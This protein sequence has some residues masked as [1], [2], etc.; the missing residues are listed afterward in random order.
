MVSGGVSRVPTSRSGLRAPVA[1]MQKSASTFPPAVSRRQPAPCHRVRVAS[2]TPS[3]E[4]RPQPVG[5]SPGGLDSLRLALPAD[6]R[7]TPRYAKEIVAVA[8]LRPAR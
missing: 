1:T 8:E 2:T 6:H 4:N 5:F 7:P 3:L